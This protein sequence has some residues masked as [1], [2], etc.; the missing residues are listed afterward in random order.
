MLTN[1]STAAARDTTVNEYSNSTAVRISYTMLSLPLI[2]PR[3]V[4]KPEALHD[5]GVNS[6]ESLL[7]HCNSS[8][9]CTH[10][11]STATDEQTRTPVFGPLTA[12][13]IPSLQ[14]TSQHPL[15]T[16][17]PTNKPS[18]GVQLIA[19]PPSSPPSHKMRTPLSSAKPMCNASLQAGSAPLG[20]P[21]RSK[22]SQTRSSRSKN[23]KPW[24]AASRS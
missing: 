14:M 12:Q 13:P 6:T 4:C 5:I 23:K 16:L 19:R 22:Q 10:K 8:S 9:G 21:R 18:H 20:Y 15:Q 1:A 2:A 3:A 17:R 11:C 7:S 24:H